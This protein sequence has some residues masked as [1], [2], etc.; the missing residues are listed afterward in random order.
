MKPSGKLKETVT[1]AVNQKEFLCTFRCHD[2]VE[3]INNQVE[4]AQRGVAG[5]T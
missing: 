3:A 2:E 4:N 5:C 1:C